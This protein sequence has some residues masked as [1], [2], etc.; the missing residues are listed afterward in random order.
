MSVLGIIW[1]G[2]IKIIPDAT[3][4]KIQAQPIPTTAD[5]RVARLLESFCAIFD[6]EVIF[7]IWTNKKRQPLE[8]SNRSRAGFKNAKMEL[9]YGPSLAC[10]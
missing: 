7:P 4:D 9:E 2:K 6:Q 10:S 8:L 5:L 3:I 1:S